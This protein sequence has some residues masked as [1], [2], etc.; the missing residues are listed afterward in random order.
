MIDELINIV[1]EGQDIEI[2]WIN[3]EFAP[4][5]L[6]T[7]RIE[8]S[9]DLYR[10]NLESHLRSHSVGP[11]RIAALKFHWPAKGRRYMWAVDDRG[12]VYRIYVAEIK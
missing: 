6:L 4:E 7:P 9:M 8:K 11:E 10:A 12:K 5:D 3:N 2:D 1:S